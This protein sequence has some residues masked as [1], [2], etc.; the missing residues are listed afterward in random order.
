MDKEETVFLE[1]LPRY[2]FKGERLERSSIL[3]VQWVTRIIGISTI[4]AALYL[5]YFNGPSHEENKIALYFVVILMILASVLLFNK[6]EVSI[7]N[8]LV[9]SKRIEI[10]EGHVEI[11]S[12]LSLG[13]S[14][15]S[16][17]IPISEID[18][19]EII[20]GD[21]SQ[22]IARNDGVRWYD[23]PIAFKLVLKN[24]KKYHSGYKPP[25]TVNDI[26]NVI[27]TRWHILIKDNGK[28]LGRGKRYNR[29]GVIGEYSYEEIM[30]MNLFEWR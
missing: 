12:G 1:R 21:G 30:R 23:S 25:N 18:H 29:G 6:S 26:M 11:P 3:V 14:E 5:G 10:N 13:F 17:I 15:K 22:Y 20:R 7:R 24:G 16:Y 27:N 2:I 19:I 28:G 4:L 9:G 8:Q